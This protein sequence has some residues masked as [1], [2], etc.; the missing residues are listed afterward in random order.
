MPYFM[1]KTLWYIYHMEACWKI[2]IWFAYMLTIVRRQK[3][4]K[5]SIMFLIL[6]YWRETYMLFLSVK[7]ISSESVCTLFGTSGIVGF[8]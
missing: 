8:E 3:G 2:T 5:N 6:S 4:F 1:T 7:Y